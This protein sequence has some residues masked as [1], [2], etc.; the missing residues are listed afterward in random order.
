MAALRLCACIALAP[1]ASVASSI[2]SSS[3]RRTPLLSLRRR[4][5]PN[6]KHVIRANK[7]AA[8]QPNQPADP[9][10][11]DDKEDEDKPKVRVLLC[12]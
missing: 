9:E 7:E 1:S 2:G 12:N 5:S 3:H 11:N 10:G 8:D 4:G 6:L